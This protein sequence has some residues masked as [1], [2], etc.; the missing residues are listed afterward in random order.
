M[1]STTRRSCVLAGRVGKA[2][3]L[4]LLLTAASPAFAQ[5][6][7]FS[8]LDPY[9]GDAANW[10]PLNAARWAVMDDGGDLRYGINTTNY[11]ERSGS[12]LGEYSLVKGRTYGDFVFSARVR[13]SEDFAVNPNADY[14]MLFGGQDGANYYYVMFNRSAASTQLFKVMGG[15][16]QPA[17]ANGSYAIPDNEYHQI[18]VSRAGSLITVKADGAVIMQADDATFGAGR[19][20][21]G[22]FNDAASWDD[23]AIAVP[24]TPDTSPPST[25]AN[26]A[27][28]ALSLS[29][30]AVS[31]S[32]ST[33]DIGVAGYRVYRDAVLVASPA[34]TSATVNGMSGGLLYAFTVAALDAAGN[35]SAQSAPVLV[36]T[37]LPVP[38]MPTIS[39]SA[40]PDTIAA[41]QSVTM[42][43]SSTNATSCTA[44]DGW[45]GTLATSGTQAVTPSATTTYILTCTGIGGI[46]SRSVLVTVTLLAPTVSL[47]ASPASIDSG[48]S[49]TLS[50][51]STNAGSCVA[52]GGWSGTKATSGSQAVSPSSTTTYGLSCTGSGG[53][54]SQS[55]TV[56]VAASSAIT[57]SLAPSRT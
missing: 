11:S 27:A 23:V 45:S 52:S 20:G 49:S 7:R 10:E 1:E 22:A 33:D 26:V 57:A 53:T 25:P 44:S 32:A 3:L 2:G 46:A 56:T 38:A 28:T 12:R 17:L 42:T 37:P 41:G 6:Q 8:D 47:S 50:W 29:E 43:W 34:G 31:W 55:A 51:S 9:L 35:A 5:V 30:V 39:F 54:G 40:V 48:G 21:I 18:E 13:S 24:A 14:A 15:V 19:L 36:T 4:A 16:R